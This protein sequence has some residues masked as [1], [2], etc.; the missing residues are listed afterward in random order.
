MQQE[1]RTKRRKRLMFTLLWLF[2][3]KRN[4]IATP[5]SSSKQAQK[6]S[7][8]EGTLLL[9]MQSKLLLPP[10]SLRQLPFLRKRVRL[11]GA[12]VS[13]LRQSTTKGQPKIKHQ[14]RLQLAQPTWPSKPPN[15]QTLRCASLS[16]SG[17]S[18]L[19]EECSL[20][21]QAL[22]LLQ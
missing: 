20:H 13:Y 18:S 2:I 12:I 7:K 22:Q 9:K 6:Q 8:L 17:R 1:Q 4:A 19:H 5:Q 21:F 16:N 15:I 11:A 10:S 14:P 3:W